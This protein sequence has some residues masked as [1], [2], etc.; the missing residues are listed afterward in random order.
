MLI[1]CSRQL[2]KFAEYFAK[3]HNLQIVDSP[4]WHFN[5]G[6]FYV[7]LANIYYPNR[8]YLLINTLDD[9]HDNLFKLCLLSHSLKLNQSPKEI[10]AV[11]P[12][13]PYSRQDK[14]QYNFSL[15][16]GFVI[17][18]LFCAGITKI[19]TYDLHSDLVKLNS[20]LE[21]QNII[22]YS[23]FANHARNSVNLNNAIVISPDEGAKKRA[24]FLAQELGIALVVA[25]KIRKN[26][27]VEIF[28]ANIP[29]AENYIIV[30][31]I[32]VSGATILKTTELIVA[33]NPSCKIFIYVTHALFAAKTAQ[34]FNHPNIL[35][36]TAMF[37]S[38]YSTNN[39]KQLSLVEM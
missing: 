17:D 22:P 26:S 3:K 18:M 33:K 16:S 4:I 23:L 8:I 21:I 27:N 2:P 14:P 6:E 24:G 34:I 7:Q 28:F 20:K 13:L 29:M 37:A 32:I 31:D 1:N 12:Y 15:A 38:K 19:I 25:Q 30:D 11:L 39:F 9:A 36:V 35:C 5:D 10:I